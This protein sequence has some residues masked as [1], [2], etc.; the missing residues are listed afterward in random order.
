MRKKMKKGVQYNM[1]VVIRGD[2]NT[3]KTSLMK[4]LQGK[5][6]DEGYTPSSQIT[7]AHVHWNYKATDDTVVLEVWDVVDQGKEENKRHRSS[8]KVSHSSNAKKPYE[9]EMEQFYS[10]EEEEEEYDNENMNNPEKFQQKILTKSA[11]LTQ[12]QLQREQELRNSGMDP[13]LASQLAKEGSYNLHTL[14][15]NIIDVYKHTNAVIF[16]FDVTKKWTFEYVQKSVP[17]VPQHICI[18]LLAN[19]IDLGEDKRVVSRDMIAEYVQ[20]VSKERTIHNIECSTKDCYGIKELY[21]YLNV[22]FLRHKIFTLEQQIKILNDELYGNQQ[23]VDFIISNQNYETFKKMMKETRRKPLQ[24]SP[25]T[26]ELMPRPAQAVLKRAGSLPPSVNSSSSSAQEQQRQQIGVSNA[27]GPIA[28][29]GQTNT[30]TAN[31]SAQNTKV[32]K[33]PNVP[34]LQQQQKPLTQKGVE[35]FTVELDDTFLKD[36][37]TGSDMEE[38]TLASTAV[39]SRTQNVSEDEDEDEFGERPMMDADIDEVNDMYITSPKKGTS[40]KAAPKKMAPLSKANQS[41]EDSTSK[42]T[43]PT[44]KV[45]I[46]QHEITKNTKPPV[47]SKE[48]EQKAAEMVLDMPS[49]DDFYAEEEDDE[50]NKDNHGGDAESEEEVVDRRE[51]MIEE[52]D[53]D[54]NFIIPKS[55]TNT[56]TTAKANSIPSPSAKE[57]SV[58]SEKQ[59]EQQQ[60]IALEQTVVHSD[61]D[62]AS[63]FYS[64]EAQDFNSSNNDIQGNQV[65]VSNTKKELESEAVD[66]ANEPTQSPVDN[67]QKEEKITENKTEKEEFNDEDTTQQEPSYLNDE[68][69]SNDKVLNIS[70]QKA[71]KISIQNTPVANEII[72]PVQSTELQLVDQEQQDE[73]DM[74]SSSKKKKKVSAKRNSKKM[75]DTESGVK[76][77]GTPTAEREPIKK[78][79]KKT[80]DP[81]K[82][83]KKKTS[84]SSSSG[85]NALTSFIPGEDDG[86]EF[87]L[88]GPKPYPSSTTPKASS[89]DAGHE[90]YESL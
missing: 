49:N 54:A 74:F 29:T 21:T 87:Q 71:V 63:G 50:S 84:T 77:S 32:A 82:K 24:A 85:N 33:Q 20:S 31:L 23:E 28:A 9:N 52:E 83:A 30:S 18:V 17:K 73:E 46:Q 25:F 57:S 65:T 75:A 66:N 10:E 64:D 43:I 34:Q 90:E 1:K 14:D 45:L 89:G 13:Q 12:Q 40:K 5:P 68:L 3:G 35:P 44:K 86:V 67:L 72:Q 38:D 76:K 39:T 26:E 60:P 81:S 22:P 79:K 48:K 53:I 47:S 4:R 56:P 27:P 7:T 55:K 19:Y 69:K 70:D 15:A 80:T 78:K 6:F 16:I 59:L 41:K 36:A 61:E 88:E 58:T 42:N 37:D 62:D 2:K 51:E 8:L 11:A